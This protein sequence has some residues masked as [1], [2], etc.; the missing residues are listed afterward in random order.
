VKTDICALCGQLR[1]LH[2]SHLL[3]KALYRLLRDSNT[4]NDNPVLISA[5]ITMQKSFQLKQPLLCT[6]C[7]RRFSENGE[8]YVIPLLRQRSGFPLLDR[9]S[10]APPLYV[11]QDHAAFI[12]P[13]AGLDGEK[14]AYF[15]LSILWR[16]AVRPWRTFDNRTMSVELESR[17]MESIRSYLAGETPFPKDAAVIATVA[18]DFVTQQMCMVPGRIPENTMYLAYGLLTKGLYYRFILSEDQPPAM[19]ATSCAGEGRNMIFVR[20]CSDKSWPAVRSLMET[21]VAKGQL[22]D[23]KPIL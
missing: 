12:C 10:R 6:A 9:L 18:T 20:D 15:G 7:E 19:R 23:T 22:A 21:T 8:N 11:R 4:A 1:K 14:I 5:Q 3:P 2:E 17:K 16:A 13:A